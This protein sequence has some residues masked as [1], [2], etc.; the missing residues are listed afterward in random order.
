[1]PFFARPAPSSA[2]PAMLGRRFGARVVLAR[3]DRLPG[4][5]FRVV[6]RRIDIAHTD[7][8]D[9]DVAAATAEVQAAFEEWI[10][11]DPGA[12]LWFYKRWSESP[13]V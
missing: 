6:L 1:M 4:A 3:T 5:R 10:R 2:F 11:D 9:A 8:M 13:V 12:W 7:D